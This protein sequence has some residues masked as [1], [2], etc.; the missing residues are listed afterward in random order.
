MAKKMYKNNELVAKRR[1][2]RLIRRSIVTIIFLVSLLIILCFNLPYFEVVNIKV[3]GNK[4]LNS[5]YITKLSGISNRVNIFYANKSKI[6]K[7][8]KT[9]PYVEDVQ[10]IKKLPNA[11]SINVKEF[12][13][14]FY[15]K[16]GNSFN[17]IN[18]NGV[19]L[20]TVDKLPND[21][22]IEITGI[23]NSQISK[24]VDV[25]NNSPEKDLLIQF[26]DLVDRNTSDKTFKSINVTDEAN[27]IIVSGEMQVKI[28][29]SYDLEKKLNVAIN[30]LSI[31]A[32]KG[33]KGYIDVSVVEKP[34]YFIE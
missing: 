1:R 5:E 22:V 11:I 31:D 6:V 32:L 20:E 34:V 2:K 4:I 7:N 12:Q 28:G 14:E 18:K 15:I 10:I 19:V 21:K 16:Q 13:A 33:K 17:L 9:E 26:A 3:E 29:T 27:I 24:G 23:K 25:F 30:I 8:I